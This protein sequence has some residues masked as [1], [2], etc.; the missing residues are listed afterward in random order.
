MNMIINHLAMV[1]YNTSD[2]LR[3]TEGVVKPAA[4]YGVI[5]FNLLSNLLYQKL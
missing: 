3:T 2:W 5:Y 1:N 4:R